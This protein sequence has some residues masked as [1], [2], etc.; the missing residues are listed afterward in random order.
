MQILRT[1]HIN[2]IW[3]DFFSMN[4]R[5]KAGIAI[6]LILSSLGGLAQSQART[7]SAKLWADSVFNSLEN[8]A[9]PDAAAVKPVL[10]SS[11]H[12]F[13]QSGD[14]CRAAHMSSWLS[15]CFDVIGQTDS[16]ILCAQQGLRWFKPTCDSLVLMSI[17]VNLSNA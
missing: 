9:F 13:L 16:A 12:F 5:S 4:W 14:T 6:L 15:H 2:L 7:T 11:L 1:G 8:K 3:T 17:N 10:D